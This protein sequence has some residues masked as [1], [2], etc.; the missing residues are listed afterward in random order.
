MRARGHASGA[1]AAADTWA[2]EIGTRW[3]GQPRNVA[4][5]RSA[6][7]G[8]SGGVTLAGLAA[9]LLA[10]ITIAAIAQVGQGDRKGLATRC[11]LGGM[12][13]SLTDSM[14]GALLQEQRWCER[15]EVATESPI[16]TCGQPTNHVRGIPGLDNDVVNLLASAAGGLA[17]AAMPA[18][19][20]RLTRRDGSRVEY[21][22][23]LTNSRLPSH[24]GAS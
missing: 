23:T 5:F 15:C 8:E 3:G 7:V 9:S 24:T 21:I 20:A 6:A 10:S 22:T 18:G 12:V 11:V 16:H 14:V 13:G 1:A 17:A 4:T 2:T 19:M